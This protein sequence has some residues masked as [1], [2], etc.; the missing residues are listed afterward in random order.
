MGCWEGK[1]KD[2]RRSRLFCRR[3]LKVPYLGSNE[4]WSTIWD[5]WAWIDWWSIG[6]VVGGWRVGARGR[7]GLGGRWGGQRCCCC[8]V[9]IWEEWGEVLVLLARLYSK[10]RRWQSSI[11]QWEGTGCC[12]RGQSFEL[13]ERR[14]CSLQATSSGKIKIWS[15]GILSWD[16]SSIS[17]F[18]LSW[19]LRI[20][21]ESSSQKEDTP[22]H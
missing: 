14:C 21:G 8:W 2:E 1:E 22:S 7:R 16:C 3:V 5:L 9:G 4:S 19:T 17:N 10:E 12:C 11:F 13:S 20:E 6:S 18:M 15:A